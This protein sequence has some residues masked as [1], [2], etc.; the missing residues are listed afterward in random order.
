MNGDLIKVIISKKMYSQ[1]I[2]ISSVYAFMSKN[3]LLLDQD[4][5]NYLVY[6][7]PKEGQLSEIIGNEFNNEL[8]NQTNY[9]IMSSQS[10]E[11]K[12][13]YLTRVIMTNDSD[14]IKKEIKNDN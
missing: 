7:K 3:Y 13:A 14:F 1:E 9:K 12:N 8:I 10:K 2:L 11:I 6:I 4:E 5:M